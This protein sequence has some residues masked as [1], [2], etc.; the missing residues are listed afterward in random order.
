MP[1]SPPYTAFPGP[2]MQELAPPDPREKLTFFPLSRLSM[3]MSLDHGWC[4]G[5]RLT[6]E[7]DTWS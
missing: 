7:S 1:I 3:R 6:Q 2:W 4:Q 5:E